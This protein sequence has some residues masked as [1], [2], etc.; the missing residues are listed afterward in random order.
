MV[1]INT[2]EQTNNR[3]Y[4]T[5]IMALQCNHIGYIK[6]TIPRQLKFIYISFKIGAI[7]CSLL[8]LHHHLVENKKRQYSFAAGLSERHHYAN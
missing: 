2:A 5:D 4:I 8:T 1:V 6:S 7:S 3:C